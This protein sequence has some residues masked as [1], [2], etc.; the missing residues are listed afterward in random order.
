MVAIMTSWCPNIL[1]VGTAWKPW[2]FVKA[3]LV[4]SLAWLERKGD[5]VIMHGQE[6]CVDGGGNST[7]KVDL[8][9]HDT[10]RQP[11]TKLLS[12]SLS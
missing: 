9:K 6:E 8:A 7:A 5:A 2:I 3:C 4:I 11:D 12:S 1:Q 10:T